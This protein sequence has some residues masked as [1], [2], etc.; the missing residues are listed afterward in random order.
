[1]NGISTKAMVDTGATLNLFLE[2]VAKRLKL[3]I[4]KEVGWLKAVNFAVKPS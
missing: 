2:E 4:S 3:Q 1:M